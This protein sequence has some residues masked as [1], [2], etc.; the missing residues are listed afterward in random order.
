MSEQRGLFEEEQKKE[1]GMDLAA[2]KNAGMLDAARRI[3]VTLA[4]ARGAE[5]ISIE[6]VRN[7]MKIWGYPFVPGNWMGSVFRGPRWRYVGMRKASH[8]GSH[9]RRVGL[10]Q[11]VG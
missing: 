8:K 2:A 11:L 4:S 10:W 7:G 3:A 1:R 6:D 5:P 9:A